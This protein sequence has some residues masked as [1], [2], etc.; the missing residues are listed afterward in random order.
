MKEVWMV[1]KAI[2]WDFGG[3]LTTSPF[4]SFNDFEREKKI[5]LDFIRGV[6]A[7]NHQDNAWAQLESSLIDAET[8]DELFF[9]ESHA[10]GHAIRGAEVLSL[11]GR[12]TV[13]PRMV[14][15]LRICKESFMNV[16]LTNN[17]RTG[18]GLAM[19]G[20]EDYAR[21][22]SDVIEL[23]DEVIESSKE[24]IRKPD[25]AIY[26]LACDRMQVDPREVVYLD[27]LGVNL[28]PARDMGMSTIKV[29]SE[30]QAIS[31][32]SAVLDIDF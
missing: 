25:R 16:C 24:G 19:S 17:A 7:V 18:K 6:N 22:V 3:V 26:S 29:I 1:F 4:D 27:D 14:D 8:F 32:L 28:K 31:D 2:L 30:S 13:R 23:F 10:L 15:V 12:Q 21:E 11:I 5:P 20:S 9:A